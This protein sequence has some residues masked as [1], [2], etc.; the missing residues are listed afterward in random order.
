MRTKSLSLSLSSLIRGDRVTVKHLHAGHFGLGDVTVAIQIV[1]T[2]YPTQFFLDRAT[3]RLRQRLQKVLCKK[4]KKKYV[5]SFIFPSLKSIVI[6]DRV[7]T[8]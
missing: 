8:R 2:K 7:V 4:K 6:N 3:R 1:E 5:H